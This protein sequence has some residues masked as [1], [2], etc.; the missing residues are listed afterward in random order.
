MPIKSNHFYNNPAMAQAAANLSALFE[1]PSGSDEAG[2]ARARADN[3]QTGQR[4]AMWD[5]AQRPDFDQSLLDRAGIIA[6]LYDP[7]NSYYSVD[8]GAATQRYGYDSAAKTSLANNAADNVR[9]LQLGR[10]QALMQPI[11]E[12]ETQFRPPSIVDL[13]DVPE[14][15]TG[16]VGAAQGEKLV[17]PDGTVVEG[18]PKPLSETEVKGGLL[19]DIIGRQSSQETAD[20][21][22]LDSILGTGLEQTVG[23]NGPVFTQ[24]CR[25]N[26]RRQGAALRRVR[27][28]GQQDL[29][30]QHQ[31]AGPQCDARG[32]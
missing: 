5:Y 2:Y 17:L 16:V 31:S 15:Q 27:R 1:P 8:T 32:K 25:G 6:D 11:G 9:A 30:R 7:S 3:L 19:T 14:S 4:Q 22:I 23:P 28:A 20:K 10:E 18:Q 12:N 26:A 21:L 13:F 24:L 29:R